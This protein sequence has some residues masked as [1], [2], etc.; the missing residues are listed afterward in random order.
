MKAIINML[1]AGMITAFCCSIGKAQTIYYQDFTSGSGTTL[2]GTAPTLAN[3]FAGGSSSATWN[4]LSNSATAFVHTD[5][6]IGA[7]Q[8]TALLSFTPTSGYVYTLTAT[9]SFTAAPNSWVALGFAGHNP[10]QNTGSAKLTDTGAT[11]PDGF[12]WL[13]ANDSGTS[14]EQYFSGGGTA[15]TIGNANLLSGIGTFTL[16]IDLDT[17][18][19]KWAISS[20]INGTQL[21]TNFT[22]SSN[23]TIAGVGLGQNS[24]SSGSSGVKWDTLE[25]TA[26]PVPEPSPLALTGVGVA[27]LVLLRRKN[28][29]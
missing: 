10:A 14:T 9:L 4:V 18:G 1:L 13:I 26:S 15:N 22:Y 5:G 2:H 28:Q 16:T 6:T 29:A 27:M 25:L 17:T 19:P 21:G 24:L 11:G 3:S 20:F 23:P 12:N 7:N 8:N